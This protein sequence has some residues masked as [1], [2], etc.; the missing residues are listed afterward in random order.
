MANRV[1]PPIPIISGPGE[2][3]AGDAE[4]IPSIL[5]SGGA[6]RVLKSDID[7]TLYWAD[8]G[9][10]TVSDGTT[11]V[12]AAERLNYT[13]AFIV[14]DNGDHIASL[15]PKFGTTAGTIAEGNHLH[16][17][18]Y[19]TE[20]E[21]DTAIATAGSTKTTGP[22]SS[23]D[24]EVAVFSGTTGKTLK[25]A[26]GSGIAKLTNGVLSVVTAPLGA[27]VGTTDTQTLTNKTLDSPILNG[28]PSI[29]SWNNAN[30]AHTG[31]GTGGNL[32]AAAVTSGVF[33]T[34]RL[35]SGTASATN[36]LRGDST[37]ADAFTIVTANSA[38][39]A[40]A[41]SATTPTCTT[42]CPNSTDIP[43][44]VIHTYYGAGSGV[45]PFAVTRN[46]SPAGFTQSYFNQSG[47]SATPSFTVICLRR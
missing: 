12:V 22:A 31:A 17:N 39:S 25:S 5:P 18:R 8:V 9:T 33:G 3:I 21:V 6:G 37:W 36:F 10:F 41:N 47:S 45:T 20:S 35:G 44:A 32:G 24:S 7:S 38:C 11:T 15:A 34:A 28:T 1:I 29:S 23:V 40:I 42:N 26:I 43:I 14:N 19:Y 46:T 13:P 4:G 2:L 27:I 30:H 16:D